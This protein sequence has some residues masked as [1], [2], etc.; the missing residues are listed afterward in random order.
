MEKICEF[1]KV[2]SILSTDVKII[3]DAL[4]YYI[5]EEMAKKRGV[6]VPGF[7]TFTFIEH[8]IYIGN[9]KELVKL[10]PHLALSERFAQTHDIHYDKAPLNERIPV[11]RINYSALRELIVTRTRHEFS[12]ETIEKVLNEAFTAIDHFL[13]RDGRVLIPFNGLGSLVVDRFK[14]TK[15]K[16]DG[17]FQFTSDLIDRIP[18]FN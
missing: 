7:G 10:K 13:R 3:W 5:R 14:V 12:R 8:R 18:Y 6:V 16:P 2:K 1:V 9:Q 11:S 15:A 4:S 17:I